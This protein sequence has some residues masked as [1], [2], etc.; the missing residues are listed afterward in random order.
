MLGQV[1]TAS[2]D[3]PFTKVSGEVNS[4][5]VKLF[6]SG[7]FRGNVSYGSGFIVSPEGHILTV[8]G[9]LL[10][11]QDLRV[12]LADGRRFRAKVLFIE[13]ELDAALLVIKQDPKNEIKLDLPYFDIPAVV[14]H[15]N[16]HKPQP[17]DWVLAS[18]NPFQIA[19]RDEPM[20]LQRG[21][22]SAYTKLV[23]RRGIFEAPYH[24][25]VIFVD[26]IITNQGSA[27]GALTTRKGELLGMIGKEFR[28]VQT[29]TWTN[30]AIPINAKLEVKYK[31]KV[32]EEF[33]DK[34][35]TVSIEELVVEGMKGTY[36][37]IK[38]HAKDEK[39]PGVYHG[40]VFVP[41]VIPQTPA[42]IDRVVKGSPAAKA[43]LK[44]DDLIIYMDGEP[45]YSIKQFKDMVLK[46]TPGTKVQL[47]IRR[48]EKLTAVELEFTDFPKK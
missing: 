3:D 11:T 34:T 32:G 5:L 6:G 48:G 8:S 7:G 27:G 10:D 42:F 25:D 33:V 38:S 4:K 9:S 22:V 39:G 37:I 40:M 12:H 30:Y 29:D 18:S 45:V 36:K 13:R 14:K 47:E 35:R 24:G 1:R 20:T 46:I 21:I 19:T 2:A 44:P 15:L 23:A 43:G 41:S 26:T 31:E 17:G 28:S 16:E